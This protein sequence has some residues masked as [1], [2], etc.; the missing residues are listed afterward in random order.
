M[1]NHLNVARAARLVGIGR[2]QIQ[3]DIKDGWLDV[4]EGDVSI[5]S[6]RLRY[7]DLCL[8]HEFEIKKA[9]RIQGNAIHKCPPEGTGSKT[10]MADRINQLQS[11]LGEAEAQIER[12]SEIIIESQH[13][14]AEMSEH[15]SRE[16]RQTLAAFINWLM[17]QGQ[18]KNW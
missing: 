6:L 5:E 8:D 7:P 17:A 4:F 14:L 10:K 16:Q 18:R 15:C 13:R 2:H 9:K 11:K 3:Q 12:Y 1:Q